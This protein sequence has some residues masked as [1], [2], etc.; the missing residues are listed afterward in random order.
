VEFNWR[1]EE[2]RQAFK[3]KKINSKQL[4]EA[5]EVL[6]LERV[7]AESVAEMP[8]TMPYQTMMQD[9]KGKDEDD[10]VESTKVKA[11]MLSSSKCKG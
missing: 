11:I 4:C 10:S 1:A 6:E 3:I 2:I 5:V 7:T 9:D 8:V